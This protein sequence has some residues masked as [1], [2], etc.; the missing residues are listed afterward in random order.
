[1]R[2]VKLKDYSNP[3]ILGVLMLA[4]LFTRVAAGILTI[5]LYLI[6]L[7]LGMNPLGVRDFGLATAT[8]VVFLN[9]A[10]RYCVAKKIWKN[11]KT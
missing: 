8:L 11:N 3:L 10:D 6:A 9:G 1:M 4:G 5:H 7:S 2:F